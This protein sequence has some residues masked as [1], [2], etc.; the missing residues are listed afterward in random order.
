LW[1]HKPWGD[2]L[3]PH[4]QL[5]TLNNT[6]WSIGHLN[7]PRNIFLMKN[8]MD[9]KH[10]VIIAKYILHV[11]TKLSMTLLILD[12]KSVFETHNNYASY[13]NWIFFNLA[14][15]EEFI[16]N[17]Y[18]IHWKPIVV[19]YK[20]MWSFVHNGV[21]LP[22][23][24]CHATTLINFVSLLENNFSNNTILIGWIIIFYLLWHNVIQL[25]SSSWLMDMSN[26]IWHLCVSCELFELRF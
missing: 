18:V 10:E 22:M 13:H 17:M 5:H 3:I 11:K 14:I 19:P 24:F 4:Q 8:H 26:W 12:L 2:C 23:V 7:R 15:T 20:G 25:I 1:H 9:N 21:S 6:N 16:S